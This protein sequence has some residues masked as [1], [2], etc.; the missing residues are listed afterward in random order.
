MNQ[1]K[2]SDEERRQR[3]KNLVTFDVAV[4]DEELKRP[5]RGWQVAGVLAMI[6]A[7]V[8]AAWL[9]RA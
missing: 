3:M 2:D 9:L 1:R 5:V 4:T 7:V 6:A 8:L